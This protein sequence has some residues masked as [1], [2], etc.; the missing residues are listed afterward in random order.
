MILSESEQ[1]ALRQRF[2]KTRG[3]QRLS[4]QELWDVARLGESLNGMPAEEWLRRMKV[5]SN[6]KADAN[7][8]QAYGLFQIKPSM[9][10]RWGFSPE[11]MFDP[12]RAVIVA[13]LIDND[14]WA[15]S[16]VRKD[17]EWFHRAY[18]SGYSASLSTDE[19]RKRLNRGPVNR[20]YYGRINAAS[21]DATFKRV[22][23]KFGGS[24]GR[25]LTSRTQL[26]DKPILQ[27]DGTPILFPNT[28]YATRNDALARVDQTIA[29]NRGT[30][31]T[32]EPANLG[33]FENEA[34]AGLNEGLATFAEA[35][36][37]ALS[38]EPLSFSGATQVSDDTEG[39]GPG[40]TG[41]ARLVGLQALRDQQERLQQARRRGE[42]PAE[43][44]REPVVETIPRGPQR[45]DRVLSRRQRRDAAALSDDPAL[46]LAQQQRA[47]DQAAFDARR[48]TSFSN[49]VATPSDFDVAAQ[50]QG[51]QFEPF[52]EP[53]E[54]A[55][56]GNNELAGGRGTTLQDQLNVA[57]NTGAAG[58]QP[59]AGAGGFT[60]PRFPPVTVEPGVQ[61]TPIRETDFIHDLANQQRELELAGGLPNE[62]EELEQLELADVPATS[63]PAPAAQPQ[64]FDRGIEQIEQFNQA[65]GYQP[66]TL[67][68]RPTPIGA[69]QGITQRR[70]RTGGNA[71]DNFIR[72]Q[73]GPN[74]T[75]RNRAALDTY[76]GLF[77]AANRTTE[78]AIAAS[79]VASNALPEEA[80]TFRERAKPFAMLRYITDR[81]ALTKL[82][83]DMWDATP[84]QTPPVSGGADGNR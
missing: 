50:A 27:A 70:R 72:T 32:R 46:Q 12:R 52:I 7:S 44:L 22:I 4:D 40:V 14:N 63:A 78:A 54:F 69:N 42:N 3:T 45:R 11:E 18:H 13:A 35:P 33:I 21:K 34:F 68:Y 80:A 62:I 56:A 25:R 39:T 20:S 74:A 58:V 61:P 71:A 10:L 65:T 79:A 77:E 48:V 36:D 31:N 43:A 30:E 83:E 19:W 41:N 49:T 57:Q 73:R 51:T 37:V 5:E 1:A 67:P 82:V 66:G 29:G 59:S 26:K 75:N 24:T 84:S 16:G 9:A 38:N 64:T 55:A 6:F 23:K 47:Q 15:Y 2:P 53:S 8:G 76:R 28:D 60:A 81:Y 17:P